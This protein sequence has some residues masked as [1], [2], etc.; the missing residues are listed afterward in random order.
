MRKKFLKVSAS[1]LLLSSMGLFFPSCSDDY[2]DD[3]SRLEQ[4]IAANAA[5]IQ[6]IQ[7]LVKSGSVISNVESSAN[8]V[9]VTLSNGKTFEITN[10]TN[11]IDGTPGTVWTIGDDDY[12]YQD[13]VKTEYL[14]RGPQGEQGIQGPQGEKGEKGD[15]GAQGEKGEKGDTGD[16]GPQGEKGDTGDQGPQGEKGEK[17]DTGATG[18]TG[19]QGEKGDK[20]DTGAQGPQG[21]RGPQGPQGDRG[22]QGP[23]GEKGDSIYYVP[24][25][26]GFFHRFVNG[27]DEG[28]TEISWKKSGVTAAVTDD[29]VI[30]SNIEGYEGTFIISRSNVLRS[31]VFE[32]QLYWGGIEA[33]EAAT[34]HYDVLEVKSV[35]A[36]ADNSTDEK[37]LQRTAPTTIDMT[38][39]LWA[40]YNMNPSNVDFSKLFDFAF[41]SED[42]KYVTRSG[43]VSPKIYKQKDN[44]D[45]TFTVYANYS[46]K[47][48]DTG[49]KVTTVALQVSQTVADET[50]TI[51]SDYAAIYPVT[52][53]IKALAAPAKVDGKNISL[54]NTTDNHWYTKAIDA[55]NNDPVIYVAW[56]SLIDVAKFV[57]THISIDNK[58][59]NLDD[60]ALDGKANNAGFKYS[61]QLVG[62]MSG[63]NKTK[64]SVHAALQ[65][66]ILRPQ[67]PDASGRQQEYGAEQN[68]ASI[69]KM[70]LVRV[71]LTDTLT[72]HVAAVGYIKVKINEKTLV[73]EKDKT[74]TMPDFTNGY[75]MK[76]AADPTTLSLTWNQI[77]A[78]LL[79]ELSITKSEFESRYELDINAGTEA[80]QFE[81]RNNEYKELTKYFGK[82]TERT[83]M[84]GEMT[85]VLEWTI[86]EQSAYEF[87]TSNQKPQQARIFVR[88]A[89]KADDY[90]YI[91]LIWA[92]DP[93]NVTPNGTLATKTDFWYQ[94]WSGNKGADELHFNVK[95]PNDNSDRDCT[96]ENKFGSAWVGDV[97]SS[98]V[99]DTY[100]GFDKVTYQF[101][102]TDEVRNPVGA[103]GTQYV[104]SVKANGN[105]LHAALASNPYGKTEKVAEIV[106]KDDMGTVK[107][108]DGT[109]PKIATVIYNEANE[110]AKDLLNAADHKELAQGETF[111]AAVKVTMKDDCDREMTFDNATYNIRFCRPISG[112]TLD[113]KGLQDG[114]DGRS[115][116]ALADILDFVDWRDYAF[117]DKTVNRT[118][119]FDY[120]GI[121]EIKVGK[122]DKSTSKYTYANDANITEFATVMTGAGTGKTV[123]EYNSQIDLQFASEGTP[124]MQNMGTISYKNNGT[125]FKED[126]TIRIPLVVKYKW[127]YVETP[128]EII[129]HPTIGQD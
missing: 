124:T 37:T 121:E 101:V 11:G 125:M 67:M 61:Y 109:D 41:I 8:G 76:C 16:Q 105:E 28:Q 19:A 62:Y 72:N 34:Y 29:D 48:P 78:I 111:T 9:T 102:I 117:K 53:D 115:S 14:A 74:I 87:F 91:E 107:T 21:D 83:D 120:Y 93:L 25:A 116:I 24:N 75:T 80:K 69:D 98:S 10:G 68:R 64:E 128:V 94:K 46:G 114:I 110:W 63:D 60:N 112:K 36:D 33:I 30:F 18:A 12:W 96:F 100:R 20:G 99:A 47:I 88:F 103:S 39:G 58:E 49:D 35:N 59:E 5:A 119:Y 50:A 65:G 31:L 22:P 43:S 2:D 70:P 73:V 45:G 51:T 104:L 23:Q 17:G 92:P 85:N 26:D 32:P 86:D 6:Q 79:K 81:L 57:Q 77:E 4:E 106:Y 129:I 89:T 95:T 113:N 126:Y 97:P 123:K 56:D 82:V 54:K 40:T 3:I 66:S 52:A 118:F 84:G 13:G 108:Q 38:P 1:V 90:I 42:Y 15:T 71:I 7:D 44:E 27:N 127:G 122:W 55:I